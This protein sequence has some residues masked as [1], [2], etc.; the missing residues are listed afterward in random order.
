MRKALF[1][2]LGKKNF[3]G[4]L[5]CGFIG[6]F[7]LIFNLTWPLL[8][9]IDL[10]RSLLT[11]RPSDFAYSALLFDHDI[12]VR[13]KSKSGPL[14]AKTVIF[15]TFFEDNRNVSVIFKD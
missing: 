5:V 8:L 15:S 7:S 6:H 9:I 2:I 10:F 14:P 12:G 4:P 13:R 3:N 1:D 11:R